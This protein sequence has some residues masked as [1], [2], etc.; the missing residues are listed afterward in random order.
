M[1]TLSRIRS[2]RRKPLS[3]KRRREL[4]ILAESDVMTVE[5]FQQ[6]KAGEK[7]ADDVFMDSRHLLRCQCGRNL[8]ATIIEACENG[9]LVSTKH[10]Q[11]TKSSCPRCDTSDRQEFLKDLND[12]YKKN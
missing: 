9:W 5:Q 11:I 6:W 10:R 1:S 3:S 8:K 7:Q 4:R 2:S 12:H